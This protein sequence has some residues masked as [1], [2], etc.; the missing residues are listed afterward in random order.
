MQVADATV[1]R[2][3]VG[4]TSSCTCSPVDRV[5]EFV[6]IVGIIR[7]DDTVIAV[8]ANIT[9]TSTQRAGDYSSMML[10]I[11]EHRVTDDDADDD[12]DDD[13]AVI[14]QRLR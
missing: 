13:D 9:E 3:A 6:S 10:R 4:S 1:T 8:S 7:Q 11:L 12:D 5:V 14:L 2:D